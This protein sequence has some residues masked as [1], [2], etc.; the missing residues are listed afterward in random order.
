MG[1]T[2]SGSNYG[3]YNSVGSQAGSVGAGQDL[4]QERNEQL[5]PQSVIVGKTRIISDA[6]DNKI[7]V[8]GPPESVRKVRTI[9]E[10]LDRRPQQVYLSTVIGQLSLTNE[11]YFGVDFTQTY[12]KISNNTGFPSRNLSSTA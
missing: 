6:K 10:R 4:L 7:I 5:G 12:K 3:G 8:I 2:Q 11:N 9:L 1:S